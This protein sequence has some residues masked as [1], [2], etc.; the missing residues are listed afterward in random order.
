FFVGWTLYQKATT[1]DE[2]DVIEDGES[3]EI[4][5]NKDEKPD[6][7]DNEED[8]EDNDDE[9]NESDKDDEA[10]DD[11][12]SFSVADEES[13]NPPEPTIDVNDAGENVKVLLEASGDQEVYVDVKGESDENLYTGTLQAGDKSEEIDI[14][15]E[16]RVHFNV[17]NSQQLTIK[18][19]DKEE[20]Y[21]TT[22]TESVNQKI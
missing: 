14:S 6:T 17:G 4:I 8:E 11:D 12:I 3:D 16:E 21:P 15:D 20:E 2:P 1:N 7:T 10:D 19:N 22:P 18:V 9:E 5:R 13:G